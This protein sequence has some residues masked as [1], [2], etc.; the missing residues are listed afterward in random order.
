MRKISVF[1]LIAFALFMGSCQKGYV[2]IEKSEDFGKEKKQIRASNIYYFEPTV[3]S[4]Y[5]RKN[6]VNQFLLAEKYKSKIQDDLQKA[7][8]KSGFRVQLVDNRA[9]QSNYSQH[10]EELL[11]L[12]RSILNATALQDNPINSGRR[13]NDNY[14]QRKIFIIP[15]RFAS[16]FA[17]LSGSYSPYFGLT[18]IFAVDAEPGS[19][20]AREFMSRN[21]AI[22]Y[23]KYY[24][25]YHMVVNI[26]TSEIIYREVKR[27]PL[28]FSVKYLPVLLW[29]SYALLKDNLK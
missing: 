7:G 27:V 22:R 6:V 14:K 24:Y 16:E 26:E 18:G 2:I 9:I 25:F 12:R 15:P 5:I 20:E 8:R 29:D 19:R 10:G 21:K 13:I 1:V 17:H 11:Q 28:K 23:G 4:Y 3:T